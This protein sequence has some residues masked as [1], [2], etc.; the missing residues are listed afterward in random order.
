MGQRIIP[1]CIR[2]VGKQGRDKTSKPQ[3]FKEMLHTIVELFK[4]E[5]VYLNRFPITFDSWYGS[6][7]LVDILREESLDQ[8]LVHAKSNYVFVI[9]GK[10][11]KLSAHKK[12]IQLDDSTWGC[13]GM[14]VA[15]REAESP[16]FGK[17]ILVF[18]SDCSETF[19][20]IMYP[21]NWTT[22]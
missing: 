8:I 10:R 2:P 19:T 15:R 21:E 4:Q 11:Q 17:V 16:T 22:H 18:F 5:G 14:P 7:D 12:E 20:N 6:D 13:K 1:L 9:G 3:I